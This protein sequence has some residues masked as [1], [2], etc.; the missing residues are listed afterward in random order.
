MLAV[1]K[2]VVGIRLSANDIKRATTVER[3]PT[4]AIGEVSI[5]CRS[6]GK[7]LANGHWVFC[8]S[9]SWS[10][11]LYDKEQFCTGPHFFVRCL[12]PGVGHERLSVEGRAPSGCLPRGQRAIRRGSIRK[13]D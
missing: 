4:F 13:A 7:P 5:L 8:V 12:S 2:C 1:V 11:Y 3:H 6:D 10:N 9:I